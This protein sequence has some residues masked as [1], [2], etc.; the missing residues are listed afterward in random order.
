MYWVQPSVSIYNSREM[1]FQFLTKL[2]TG[3]MK[4]NQG[5]DGSMKKTIPI[6]VCHMRLPIMKV[7]W[8]LQADPKDMHG[9]SVNSC[10]SEESENDRSVVETT[11]AR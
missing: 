3:Q 5:S 11:R 4:W 10:T 1:G 9:S 7:A 8:R 2:L 6:R